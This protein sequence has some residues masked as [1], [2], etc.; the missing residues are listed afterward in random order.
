[1]NRQSFGDGLKTLKNF[2]PAFKISQEQAQAWFGRLKGF[3]D[4]AMS[5]A[6]FNL[7]EHR[8]TTPGYQDLKESLIQASQRL[9]SKH[10]GASVEQINFT[11]GYL[12]HMRL[13]GL[14]PVKVEGESA[15]TF[16]RISDC[17]ID[18]REPW[19]LLE[20]FKVNNFRLKGNTT[21]KYNPVV[22]EIVGSLAKDLS[23]F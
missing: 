12:K 15:Y 17:Y 7:T 8:K 19:C 4:L 21:I 10:M 3:D 2:F 23:M 20:G 6:V 11:R 16:E 18:R 9:Y 22:D 1:M 13:Y 14:V 5:E